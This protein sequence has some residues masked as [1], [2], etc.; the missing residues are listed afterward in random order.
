MATTASL[1]RRSAGGVSGG[2]A[3][4]CWRSLSDW[5]DGQEWWPLGWAL[6]AGKQLL[7]PGKSKEPLAASILG[8]LL[9]CLP[10]PPPPPPTPYP[11]QTFLYKAIGVSLAACAN[12]NLVQKQ[13]QEL[14]ETARYQE[15]AER[16]VGPGAGG[17]KGGRCPSPGCLA[18]CLLII[19]QRGQRE[20]QP[21]SR[22]PV[23][24]EGAVGRWSGRGCILK[25]QSS[26][27]NHAQVGNSGC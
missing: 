18:N 1:Q 9:R 23:W 22:S 2:G 17:E 27:A 8:S 3:P 10:P 16:E 12:K 4:A 20:G 19:P 24:L 26:S 15:E 25:A 5:E 7:L 21:R 14:L 13:L 6:P 11:L